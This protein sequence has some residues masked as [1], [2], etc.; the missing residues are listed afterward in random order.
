MASRAGTIGLVLVGLAAVV[1]VAVLVLRPDPELPGVVRD[2]A[3]DVH[4]LTFED[5]WQREE[6]VTV[7]LVPAEGEL[8]LAYFGYLSC[9]DMCPLTMGDLR[10]A[11][12]LV[13]EERSARTT[14]AFVTLD[15]GRDDPERLN[16]YLSL[17]FDDRVLALTA[18]DEAALDA[19][20][21]QLGVRFELEEPD[22]DGHYEVLH[23]AITYVIDDRGVVV[24]ELP[25]GVPAEDVA[26]VI[27]ATLR[28]R[29]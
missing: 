21:A 23:S 10:R 19:A 12:Q 20:A 11:R 3:P 8:T 1:A 16:A 28:E 2:P 29:S 4:G 27:E 26:R 25:F 18:P 17:F 14:V 5:V 6:A 15:P 22:A 7:D 13:G 24:R 9:P